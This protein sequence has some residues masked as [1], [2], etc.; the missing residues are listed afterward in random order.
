M[1]DVRS[2]LTHPDFQ[3]STE[4]T[5]LGE[6]IEHFCR[7]AVPQQLGAAARLAIEG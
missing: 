6:R 5:S 4:A 7:L 1:S 2:D 3:G